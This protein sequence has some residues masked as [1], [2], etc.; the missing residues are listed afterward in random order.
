MILESARFNFTSFS[1]FMPEFLWF[2]ISYSHFVCCIMLP[3]PKGNSTMDMHMQ[4]C[5]AC[6]TCMGNSKPKGLKS[7]EA[8]LK[9]RHLLTSVLWFLACWAPPR[10][11]FYTTWKAT[12][13][14]CDLMTLAVIRAGLINLGLV[15]DAILT[16]VKP[17]FVSECVR[18]VNFVF[19]PSERI[20]DSSV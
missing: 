17:G 14:L 1:Y 18:W 6:N 2:S 5:L 9:A 20:D 7:G 10:R 19:W 16:A 12:L 15:G 13:D 3:T 8:C 11:D 4:I